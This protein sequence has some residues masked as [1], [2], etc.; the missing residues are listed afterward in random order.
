MDGCGWLKGDCWL[1]K[2]K[3][4]TRARCIGSAKFCFTQRVVSNQ[5]SPDDVKDFRLENRDGCSSSKQSRE[6]SRGKL[7]QATGG[8]ERGKKI[9][10]GIHDGAGNTNKSNLKSNDKG[11]PKLSPDEIISFQHRLGMWRRRCTR[12]R[13]WCPINLRVGSLSPFSSSEE[14]ICRS[15]LM[16]K[17]PRLNFPTQCRH[18]SI[19]SGQ[20]CSNAE[21]SAHEQVFNLSAKSLHSD[22]PRML[23]YGSLVV[24]FLLRYNSTP[25]AKVLS[26]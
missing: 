2:V 24:L 23:L 25:L 14:V 18:F 26:I 6:I 11:N 1:G 19:S 7:Q 15:N 17:P 10:P 21:L 22:S 12:R 8:S 13:S 9:W 20:K 5:S 16:F 4:A 3:G